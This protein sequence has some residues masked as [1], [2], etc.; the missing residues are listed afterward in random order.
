MQYNIAM[1]CCNNCVHCKN[2][3]GHCKAHQLDSIVGIPSIFFPCISP[4]KTGIERE[5]KKGLDKKLSG[6]NVACRNN[7]LGMKNLE[8]L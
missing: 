8:F 2:S 5:L 7:K 6:I 3:E 1:R 4:T